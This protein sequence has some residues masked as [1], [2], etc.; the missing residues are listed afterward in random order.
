M[1]KVLLDPNQ[2]LHMR[3]GLINVILHL[4]SL[5]VTAFLNALICS[6]V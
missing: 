3:L 5:G 6:R 4:S 1:F 2:Y